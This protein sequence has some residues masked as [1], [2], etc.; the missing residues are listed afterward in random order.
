MFDTTQKHQWLGGGVSNYPVTHPIVGQGR[1]YDTFKQFIYTVD[2][3]SDG[4]AHVFAIIAQWGIG[5]SRLAYELISQI[6]GTSR[7][8]YVRDRQSGDLT[9]AHLFGGDRPSDQY[10][11]L[12]IRYSNVANEHHN[13][14]NWFGYGLYKA[15]RPL[16]TRQSRQSRQSDAKQSDGS[17]QDAI[18][19]EAYDRLLTLGFDETRLAACLEID[20]NHSDETLYEDPYLV[21]RLCQAAYAYLQEFGIQYILVALDELE[22]VAETSTYGLEDRDIKHMDGRAIKL[23][24]KAIKEEDPRRKLPWLRYVALC[25]PAIGDELREIQSTARRFEL[26]HLS[27]NAFADV[28]DFVRI[29]A[30]ENRLTEQ[31]LPGLVEAAYTM[32]GGNFGWFNVIMANIDARLQILRA[33][34]KTSSS[35]TAPTIVTLFDDLIESTARIRDYILDQSAINEL[36]IPRHQLAIAKELL[37]GQLPTPI[38]KWDAESR[39]ILLNTQNEYNEAIATGYRRVEWDELACSDALR[40][41]KFNRVQ[42]DDWLLS[43]VDQPLSLQQLLDNL[44]TYAITAQITSQG[45]S[46]TATANPSPSKYTID[47][48]RILLIPLTSPQFIELISFLYPH[49]AAADAARALWKHL[50]QDDAIPETNMTHIGPSVAMLERLDLRYRKRN[51]TSLIFRD[52]EQSSAHDKLMVDRQTRDRQKSAETP[53]T[54]TAPP[55]NRP[56]EIL[57]GIMRLLDRNWDYDPITSVGLPADLPAITTPR[58]SRGR[59]QGGLVSYKHL[60]IHPKSRVIFAWVQNETELE[61]LCRA[62]SSQFGSEGLTPILAF[63][64]SRALFDRFK[65][66]STD[67]LKNA[68]N[69]LLLY[70]LSNNE[71]YI[72]HAI[73]IP[74]ASQ[75]GFKLESSNFNSAFTQRL[76][77]VERNLTDEIQRWRKTLN[78]QGKIAWS[79]RPGGTL[80]LEEKTLL[81]QVWKHLLLEK[82]ANRAIYELDEHSGFDTDALKTILE[83]LDLPR[84]LRVEGYT[85][86]EKAELFSG[87]ESN[88][89]AEFPPFLVDLLGHLLLL[90]QSDQPLTEA[91]AKQ[92]YFWG[93][94][95]FGS[96]TK[97]IFQDW[98]NLTLDLGFA[99]TVKE[100]EYTFLP[101]SQLQG[102]I[103]AAENW[104]NQDYTAMINK[105]IEV[106]GEG[107]IRH[108]FDLSQ[109]TKTSTAVAH[110][111]TAK[112]RLNQLNIEEQ[113][114]RNLTDLAAKRDQLI[115]CAQ[116]RCEIIRLIDTVYNADEYKNFREDNVKTLNLQNDDEPLWKRIKR[117]DLFAKRVLAIQDEI[118]SQIQKLRETMKS[119]SATL[120]HFPIQVFTLS[121]EK[122]NNILDGAIGVSTP[123]G[124]TAQ[125]QMT[126]ASALGQCLRDLRIADALNR[127][128][129]LSREVGL[130][131]TG[132]NIEE[133][134]FEQIDGAIVSTF[135][136]FKQGFS[137]LQADLA[138]AETELQQINSTLKN[139]PANFQYP[140]TLEP[141]QKLCQK[142]EL[143]KDSLITIH[144]EEA[145]ALR[146]EPAFDRAAKQGNFQPLM[147]EIERLLAPPRRQINQLKSDL[148]TLKNAIRGYFQTLLNQEDIQAIEHSINQLLKAKKQPLKPTLTLTELESAGSLATAIAKLEERRTTWIEESQK[149]LPAPLTFDR[150][151]TIVTAIENGT[152][153]QLQPSEEQALITTGLLVRT[154][155]L[156]GA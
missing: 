73:G 61:N 123:L 44:S 85:P 93:Y 135:R 107:Q 33:Q 54:N 1:F 71:E 129:G 86:E 114:Y 151:Q 41:A 83:K 122:I 128:E 3:D 18:T 43:G 152:D 63:T 74:T 30:D 47:G 57:T 46:Q 40:N 53:V 76:N 52:P 130:N 59:D 125:Q 38:Q 56:R 110:L 4:F 96:K 111:K 118:H 42:Q 29:L 65:N 10:L 143:I 149:L 22:T 154:Y 109:G 132:S 5:K 67:I 146:E 100:G 137:N 140:P 79:F 75:I 142:P 28:S 70:Q 2:Q 156:G 84:D 141:L 95:W 99:Q 60:A 153:P 113:T 23:L 45:T 69:Y 64:P 87:S 98:M 80:K 20:Q 89:T 49:P 147:Q 119:Q 108:L 94:T 82:T 145:E 121:L 24:S 127:L 115:V 81:S 51:Q 117:A 6:N 25:S 55:E 72:L 148:L 90:G 11:G 126:D 91:F 106:F 134:Q 124:S 50:I 78:A 101:V 136:S 31:Y 19:Q 144:D 48:K 62:A 27:Q 32:S 68:K 39:Q 26:V 150:W 155:R 120:D 8:W 17:I 133:I 97:D 102:R 112:E 15:L 34:Q 77:A 138:N 104:F 92:H 116:S 35:Q 21:T 58:S 103:Q 12:Y 88:A 37:Y 105:M 13:I 16:A 131:I 36:K 7:G 139:A 9:Q 66:P 14:D